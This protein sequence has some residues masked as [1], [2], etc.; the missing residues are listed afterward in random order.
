MVL[1]CIGKSA[2]LSALNT[3]IRDFVLIGNL[4]KLPQ[5]RIV[6]PVL[7]KMFGVRFLIP[8]NAE[9]RT[10]VGAALAFILGH[11]VRDVPQGKEQSV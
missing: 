7:E 6:F 2:I 5:C 11:P 1:Q 9:Y 8:E 10:A 4:T 3:P